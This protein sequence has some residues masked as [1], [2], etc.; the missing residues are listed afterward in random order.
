[1]SETMEKTTAGMFSD[2][3]TDYFFHLILQKCIQKLAMVLQEYPDGKYSHQFLDLQRRYE[4]PELK[5]AVIG[6]FNTGKSTFINALLKRNYLSTANVPTTVIPTYIRWNGAPGADPVIK[7]RLTGDNQEYDLIANW[8]FLQRKLGISLNQVDA[9]ERITTNNALIGVVSQVSVSFPEDKRFQNFCLIDTPGTNPGS[10]ETVEH[11]NVTRSVLKDEADATII[12]FPASTAGNRSALEFIAENASHLLKGSAFIITKA[13]MLDNDKEKEDIK[14]Y[15][16]GL[17]KQRYNLEN[18]IIYTCSAKNALLAYKNR[19][20]SEKTLQDFN[21]MVD[22]IL[23]ELRRKRKQLIFQKV[24]SLMSAI[25][26]ELRNKQDSLSKKLI[27]DME[28]LEKYSLEKLEVEYQT[29]FKE[30]DEELTDTWE[31]LSSNVSS[32]ISSKR[33]NVYNDIASSVDSSDGILDLRRYIKEDMKSSLDDFESS[34]KDGIA[35]D[36]RKMESL[37]SEFSKEVFSILKK[38]QLKISSQIG[39]TTTTASSTVTPGV[40]MNVSI[41]GILGG[42]GIGALLLGFINPVAIVAAVVMLLIFREELFIRMK[43]NVKAKVD[44]GLRE[45]SD[46]VE[47]KW[48]DVLDEVKTQYISN[49]KNLMEN[50]RNQYAQI[51]QER[52]AA[53]SVERERINLELTKGKSILAEIDVMEY[54]LAVPEDL[55]TYQEVSASLISQALV[56]DSLA[57]KMVAEQYQ[58]LFND[59]KNMKYQVFYQQWYACASMMEGGITSKLKAWWKSKWMK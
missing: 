34:I 37:Y 50:Y 6:E 56:G 52:M 46:A 18:Q 43:N 11:V 28:L 24:S 31:I 55:S 39:N 57:A 47:T 3:R 54:A 59:T 51:F 22:E 25:L 21:D 7:I 17:V 33:N 35:S 32:E 19:N 48:I 42:L 2:T 27:D 26:E 40:A 29:N 41:D 16:R 36:L 4:D 13:D 10:E 15:L 8:Q 45:A 14:K 38:Y 58:I 23:K 53:D 12:L 1:M 30:F 20:F 44:A 49:G 9:L 5:L